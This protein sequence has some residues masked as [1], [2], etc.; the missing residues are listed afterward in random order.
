[1]FIT[2]LAGS[3]YTAR[4]D[5]SDRRAIAVAQGNLTGIAHLDDYDPRT[6]AAG[7]RNLTALSDLEF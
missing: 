7:Q 6:V 3:I 4:L 5:G 2:D 1:M